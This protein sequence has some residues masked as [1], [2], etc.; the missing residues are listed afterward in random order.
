MARVPHQY[1][2]PSVASYDPYGVGAMMLKDQQDPAAIFQAAQAKAAAIEAAHQ[3]EQERQYK[4]DE[5]AREEEAR[6]QLAEQ[7][8]QGEQDYNAVLDQ[9]AKIAAKQ[10]DVKALAGIVKTKFGLGTDESQYV[11]TGLK[12][13]KDLADIAPDKAGEFYGNHGGELTGAIDGK[14]LRGAQDIYEGKTKFKQFPTGEKIQTG[15]TG[16]AGGDLTRTFIDP[17]TGEPVTLRGSPDEINA[18]VQAQHL[19]KGAPK[20]EPPLDPMNLAVGIPQAIA[21]FNEN[22]EWPPLDHRIIEAAQ[23]K[24]SGLKAPTKTSTG[25]A[26]QRPQRQPGE[27]FIGNYKGK[28]T[29]FRVNARGQPEVI[30]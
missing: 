27:E 22:N 13:S 20:V 5:L 6:K 3:Q 2:A 18:A 8:A 16:G 28:P 10:G 26:P 4:L 17:D 14:A 30:G 25:E 24:V 1:D 23:R 7:A 29:K 9:A 11:G 15:P 12:T 19:L 21:D